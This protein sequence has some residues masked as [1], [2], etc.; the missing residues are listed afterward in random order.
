MD[1]WGVQ[2]LPDI[3]SLTGDSLCWSEGVGSAHAGSDGEWSLEEATA[4]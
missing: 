3:L 4:W 1:V 2:S